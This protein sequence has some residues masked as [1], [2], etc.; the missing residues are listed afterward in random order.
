MVQSDFVP[1]C[2]GRVM[3]SKTRPSVLARVI[4]PKFLLDKIRLIQSPLPLVDDFVS[5]L[6]NLLA[7]G[8]MYIRDVV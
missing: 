3:H 6:I 2:T 4:P 7:A 5:S 1:C 8:Y